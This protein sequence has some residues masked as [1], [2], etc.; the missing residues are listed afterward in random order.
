MTM[1]WIRYQTDLSGV[2][3]GVGFRP[4]LYRLAEAHGLGGSVQNRSGTVRLILE[5][6]ADRVHAFLEVLPSGLPS[7]ARIEALHP[8]TETPIAPAEASPVFLI[9]ESARDDNR[10]VALPADLAL[11]PAC[12]HE[13]F[14][15]ADRRHGYAFTTCV[16]CGPRYT[17]VDAMPYDRERT[18]MA[19]FPLCPECRREYT[20]PA[21]RRFHAESIACPACGPRLRFTDGAGVAVEGD[22]LRLT[23]RALAEGRIVAIRGLGGFLLAAD[24]HHRETITRL[25]ALKHRPHKPFA[26]MAADLAAAARYVHLPP[27]A[28]EA[29]DSPRAPILI[30]AVRDE[31]SRPPLPLDL[32]TP[33]TDTLG[34]M[35]PTTALHEL[36]FHPLPGDAAPAFDLLVMTSGNRRGEPIALSNEEALERLSGLAEAFLL[37]DRD[38]RLR[39]DDSVGVLQRGRVQLWRRARGY[40]PDPVRLARP[41]ARRVLAM[42]AELKNAVALGRGSELVLSPHIG[43]LET[44]EAVEGMKLVA[45]RLPRFLECEPECIAVDLHPDMH[46]TR[47]GRILAERAGLPLVEVPH[48]E[49]HAAAALAE[50][51]LEEALALVFDGTGLGTD[52]TLWGAE[53]FHARPDRT[54]RLGTFDAVPLPGGDAAVLDPRRQLVARWLAADLVPSSAWRAALRL[55]DEEMAAWSLQI[56]RGL[57]APKTHAAGRVFDAFAAAAGLAHGGVTYE[58]QAAIRLENRARHASGAS[59]ATP[60]AYRLHEDADGLLRIDWSPLF[61]R[62]A[63]QTPETMRTPAIALA[64]HE[65]MACAALDM[66]RYGAER[67][68]VRAVT[69]SGGVF[70]NR[71]LNELLIPRLEAESFRVYIHRVIPPNDGGIAAGQA[72]AA[73][74]ATIR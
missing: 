1:R 43:D 34:V 3:Q 26:V 28:A 35:R 44:P 40:A 46:S 42:G 31:A 13:L 47:W 63:G 19:V 55:T 58:G 15:P 50:H 64:F 74:W 37:H 48:H 2:V 16:D 33:D 72:A 60:A 57:H 53:L 41:L 30:L 18:S 49:A 36:L 5:G 27:E 25:R 70:M 9:L 14:D 17:V 67:T 38:I 32:L 7:Q 69:L 66:A 21:N 39:N 22:P 8:G 11:C 61:I 4:A 29:M 73:G 24:A 65:A 52:G 6:P 62:L 54:T 20:D 23:R 56:A 45:D 51:G 59:G 12:T 68:G 71:L 10:A